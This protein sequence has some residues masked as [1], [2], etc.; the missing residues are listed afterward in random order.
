MLAQLDAYL[1]RAEDYPA[2]YSATS[3]LSAAD[4]H[5]ALSILDDCLMLRHN[6]FKE[7]DA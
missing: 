6:P 2:D 4:L 3:I 5:G 7:R 1:T